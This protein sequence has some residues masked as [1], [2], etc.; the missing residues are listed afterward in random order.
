MQKLLEILI[1]RVGLSKLTLMIWNVL[2]KFLL[3][4]VKASKNELDNDALEVLNVIVMALCGG[5]SKEK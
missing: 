1:K 5:L 4:K 3:K 2:Y